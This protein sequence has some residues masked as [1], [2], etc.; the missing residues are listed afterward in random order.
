M[1]PMMLA[2]DGTLPR[3]STRGEVSRLGAALAGVATLGG[4]ALAIAWLAGADA[5]VR[6]RP[7]PATT[8]FNAAVAIALLGAATTWL[9]RPSSGGSAIRQPWAATAG[10]VAALLG[11]ASLFEDVTG[12]SLGI[13]Q[14][15]VKDGLGRHGRLSPEIAAVLVL[16]G[17]G[18]A[19]RASRPASDRTGRAA[20][21]L[22][23]VSAL[24]LGFS[25]VELAGSSPQPFGIT[26]VAR[27]SLPAVVLLAFT[28]LAFDISMSDR[29][30]AVHA[31]W[32][33]PSMRAPM[34]RSFVL[35]VPL[36]TAVPLC[37]SVAVVERN[38][39][40]GGSIVAEL[41]TLTVAA[42]VVLSARLGSRVAARMV[43]PLARMNEVAARIALGSLGAPGTPGSIDQPSLI[44]DVRGDDE[45]SRLSRAFGDM[46]SQLVADARLQRLITETHAAAAIAP[47]L[48][49]AFYAFTERLRTDLQFDAAMFIRAEG[50]D[51]IR[52][53]ACVGD[54]L[55]RES[56]GQVVGISDSMRKRFD[57]LVPLVEHDLAASTSLTD[58]IGYQDLRSRGVRSVLTIPVVA[59]GRTRAL[60]SFFSVLPNAFGPPEVSIVQSVVR[61][62]AAVFDT[63]VILERERQATEQLRDLDRMKN[64]FVGMV[65]HDLRSPMGVIS[66]FADTLRLRWDVLTPEQRDQF[67][68]TIS[69]NV[70]GLATMVEDMLHAARIEAGDYHYEITSFPLGALVARTVAEVSSAFENRETF[71]SIPEDLP[72]V[73]GDQQ[74]VWQVLTNLLSNAYKFSDPMDPVSVKL[75]KEPNA[76]WV[77]VEVID[78]GPGIASD[79]HERVFEKFIRLTPPPGVVRPKGTG[80]GLYICRQL[81]EAQRGRIGVESTPGEGSKFWFILPVGE[82]VLDLEPE[83]PTGLVSNSSD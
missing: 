66:G 17:I 64:E 44:G 68:Q 50:T 69:R 41:G 77:R 76:P 2:V 23:A 26:D 67:L 45:I 6:T 73:R 25:A 35:P 63:L 32:L 52:V 5:L 20:V 3:G 61:E 31:L 43:E 74:R 57:S 42:L 55:W 59:I 13:D 78:G 82:A 54:L 70:L 71:M 79:Q 30:G 9:C 51:R 27:V 48:A 1:L 72:P 53:E 14:A 83:R 12:W 62:T 60:V 24:V 65:A 21:W 15:V 81:I 10:G 8:P 75:S 11:A 28:T 39:H 29:T 34:L 47:D 19:V 16:L 37:V 33:D 49:A 58:D 22:E 7:G 38:H 40:G 36:V 4:V 80:L 56:V 46:H 18:V